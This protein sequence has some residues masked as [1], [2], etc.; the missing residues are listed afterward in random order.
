MTEREE[1]IAEL[2]ARLLKPSKEA[3]LQK[4]CDEAA[5]M[6]LVLLEKQN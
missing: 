6:L 1:Y 3:N 2:I 5:K 4:L